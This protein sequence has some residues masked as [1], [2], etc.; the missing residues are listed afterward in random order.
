MTPAPVKAVDN[1]EHPLHDPDLVSKCREDLAAAASKF[2]QVGFCLNDFE[3]LME[4]LPKSVSEGRKYKEEEM[5]EVIDRLIDR[6]VEID[7]DK[8]YFDV[9]KRFHSRFDDWEPLR[10]HH[11]T[12]KIDEL[13]GSIDEITEMICGLEIDYKKTREKWDPRLDILERENKILKENRFRAELIL[14]FLRSCYR[15]C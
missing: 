15:K 9:L 6:L 11:M 2:A 3:R 8:S 5:T 7:G 10:H 1:K 14:Q 12:E 13:Y 4:T